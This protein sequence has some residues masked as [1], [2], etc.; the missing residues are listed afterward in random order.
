MV[1]VFIKTQNHTSKTVLF[2]SLRQ[3]KMRTPVAFVPEPYRKADEQKLVFHLPHK[4]ASCF[5]H[6]SLPHHIS[7]TKWTHHGKWQPSISPTTMAIA[8]LKTATS[9]Y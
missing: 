4:C 3:G 6:F 2:Y 5:V 7:N 9:F 8:L 1:E